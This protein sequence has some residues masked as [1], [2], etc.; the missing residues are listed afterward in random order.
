[1]TTAR[2]LAVE[3]QSQLSAWT[4]ANEQH[5]T[6]VNTIDATQTTML[7]LA[8]GRDIG[9]GLVEIDSELIYLESYEPGTQVATIP[10]WGR[11]YQGSPGGSHS[12]GSRVIVRPRFPLHRV[13][14]TLN[15]V[16][17][18][19]HPTLFGVVTDETLEADTVVQTYPFTADSQRILDIQYEDYYDGVWHKAPHWTLDKQAN[20]VDYPSGTSLTVPGVLPGRP[21]K[22]TYTTRPLPLADLDAD[23]ATTGL[24]P[25]CEDILTLGAASRLV[26]GLELARLD[27]GSPHQSNAQEAVQAGSATAASKYLYALQQERIQQ[28]RDRLFQLYPLRTMRYH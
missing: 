22:V 27:V 19:L 20:S 18:G 16:I 8:T 26:L 15:Q 23:F 17:A 3:V 28:E 12:A 1:M 6:L 10:V 4:I 24:L 5:G 7:L 9:P 14:A 13:L 21:L 25:G 11:E 2:E